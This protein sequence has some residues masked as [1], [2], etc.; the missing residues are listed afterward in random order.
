VRE[1][2]SAHLEASIG[3]VLLEAG[4]KQLDKFVYKA[5]WSSADVEHFIYLDESGKRKGI[6]AGRFGIRNPDAEAFKCRS[7]SA[8]QRRISLQRAPVRRTQELHD[9]FPLRTVDPIGLVLLLQDIAERLHPVV[10]DMTTIDKFLSFLIKDGEPFWWALTNGAIRAAQIGALASKSGIGPDQIR[11]MLQPRLL[12]I[13]NGFPRSSPMREDP[14]AYVDRILADWK[15][16]S[17]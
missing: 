1:N 2:S 8:L 11:S 5:I 17:I 4:Y 14:A 12:L 15:A 9:A 3:P 7:Y 16:S 13:A 6:F 10:R